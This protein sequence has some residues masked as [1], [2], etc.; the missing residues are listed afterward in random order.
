MFGT[1]QF[2][3]ENSLIH[4]AATTRPKNLFN[5]KLQMS[6]IDCQVAMA[7]LQVLIIWKV[8]FRKTG[9]SSFFAE[10]FFAV[11]VF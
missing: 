6:T 11:I 10:V 2:P 7:A 9:M 5:C 4:Q 3:N 8:F 1:H